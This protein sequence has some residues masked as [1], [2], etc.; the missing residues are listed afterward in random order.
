MRQL[1]GAVNLGRKTQKKGEIMKTIKGPAIIVMAVG[2]GLLAVIAAC[3]AIVLPMW[4]AYGPQI[5]QGLNLGR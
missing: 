1:S 3:A 2:I 5:Q 4:A